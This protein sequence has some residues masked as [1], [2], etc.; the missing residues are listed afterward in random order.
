MVFSLVIKLLISSSFHKFSFSLIFS[1]ISTRIVVCPSLQ[2]TWD[3]KWFN[4][5]LV[6]MWD[7]LT[8]PYIPLCVCFLRSPWFAL[9][10]TI[11]S[12]FGM[13]TSVGNINFTTICCPS[14]VT[15]I[16]QSGQNLRPTKICCIS[17][18]CIIHDHTYLE[19]AKA[20]IVTSMDSRGLRKHKT[21]DPQWKWAAWYLTQTNPPGHTLVLSCPQPFSRPAL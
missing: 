8:G 10:N 12:C 19:S 20:H 3:G 14:F 6:A 2:K 11:H 18:S 13:T 1:H 21:K 15:P 4:F 9:H 17:I 5:P 7:F 16:K